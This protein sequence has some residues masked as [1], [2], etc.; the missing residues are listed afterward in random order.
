MVDFRACRVRAG[1]LAVLYAVFFFGLLRGVP[2]FEAAGKVARY[3]AH[4]EDV[5]AADAEEARI[6]ELLSMPREKLACDL[7]KVPYHGNDLANLDQLL[8]L[9]TPHYGIITC[10]D[11][12]PEEQGKMDTLRQAGVSVFLTRNGNVEFSSNGVSVSVSQ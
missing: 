5:F 1:P 7:M 8:A 2:R 6:A 12:N 11:K 4:P 9:A 3:A 10:S